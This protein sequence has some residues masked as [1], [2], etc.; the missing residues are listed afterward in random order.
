MIASPKSVA[1]TLVALVSTHLLSLS[2][3]QLSREVD[4]RKSQ[5]ATNAAPDQSRSNSNQN[6]HRN[7]LVQNQDKY[8]HVKLIPN[9][10]PDQLYYEGNALDNYRCGNE[11]RHPFPSN[12]QATLQSAYTP[13]IDA[14]MNLIVMGDSLAMQLSIL[15]QSAAFGEADA[16]SSSYN[17]S[18]TTLSNQ[19]RLILRCYSK[20]CMRDVYTMA[21]TR[22]GSSIAAWRL[23]GMLQNAGLS[24]PL[25]PKRGGGWRLETL[26]QMKEHVWSS[27]TE[28][29]TATATANQS[30]LSKVMTMPIKALT[31]FDVMLF[32]IPQIWI[33][34]R[35]VNNDS[36][37]ETVELASSVFGVTTIIFV[38]LPLT[39]HYQDAAGVAETNLRVRTFVNEMQQQQRH[40][41]SNATTINVMLLELGTLITELGAWNAGNLGY[42]ASRSDYVKH[43]IPGFHGPIRR[44]I[45]TNCLEVPSVN[46]TTANSTFTASTSSNATTAVSAIACPLNMI[47]ADGVHMC[48]ETF[49]PRIVAGV[50]CLVHCANDADLQTCE[51]MCNEKWMRLDLPSTSVD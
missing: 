13:Y 23:T 45:A 48:M 22:G 44:P 49:G 2:Q 42:N 4:I 38:N 6:Q 32:R 33:P 7:I 50:G 24:K 43:D 16:T 17:H 34:L 11:G 28:A 29:T 19:H 15:L 18:S 30:S 21:P 37:R 51:Q 8:F 1:F 12:M 31:S 3:L 26:Q 39:R 20:G 9:A 35:A 46:V 25:P 36:L 40:A 47:F 41:S 5:N 27:Q 14:N 10:L